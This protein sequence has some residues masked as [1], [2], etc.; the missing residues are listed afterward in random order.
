MTPFS[1]I[2]RWSLL[3]VIAVAAALPARAQ[4]PEAQASA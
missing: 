2:R 4:S 3:V 1:M